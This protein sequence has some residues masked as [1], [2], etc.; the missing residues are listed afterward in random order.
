MDVLWSAAQTGAVDACIAAARSGSPTLLVVQGESG[1]GKSS[2]LREVRRRAAG[3][4]ALRVDGV[5]SHHLSPSRLLSECDALSEGAAPAADPFGAAQ[6]LRRRLDAVQLTAPVLLMLDDFQ[7]VTPE[8]AELVGH[9]LR[10]SGGDRLLVAVGH[11][12][13]RPPSF[14]EWRH[15]V[16]DLDTRVDVRLSGLSAAASAVLIRTIAPDA[17][18]VLIDRLV[19]HTGGNPLY[20][21]SIL[22]EYS[23]DQLIRSDPLPAPAD[24][25]AALVDRVRGM[26]GQDRDLLWTIAILG[27][28]WVSIGTV[29]AVSAS[30]QP[31]G[32]LDALRTDGLVMSRGSGPDTEVRIFHQI[33]CAAVVRSVPADVRRLVLLRAA[34]RETAT[35]AKLQF[36]FAAAAGPDDVLAADLADHARELHD[37]GDFRRA[38]DYLRWSQAVTGDPEVRGDRFGEMWS[39]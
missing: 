38:A 26:P 35:D 33:V 11:R 1:A 32:A 24:L 30:S 36:R 16:R 13:I 34:E 29:T 8:A 4:V 2:L 22:T 10:R 14:A 3:F 17:D 28:G 27:P 12:E 9:V 15:L 25:V 18:Q 19:S 5:R 23:L 7:W 20:L 6:L 39:S 21:R 37:S 31:L